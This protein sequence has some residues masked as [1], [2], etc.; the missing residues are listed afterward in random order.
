MFTWRGSNASSLVITSA[1]ANGTAQANANGT[2]TYAPQTGF[3]GS[4]TFTYTVKD[5]LGSTSNPATVTVHVPQARNDSYNVT[6]N[7]STSQTVNAATV[8]LNGVPNVAGR[9]FARQSNPVRTGGTGTGTLTITSFNTSTG[10]FSYRLSGAQAA[11]RGT[12][13]F[14][15]RMSLGGVST[16]PATVTIVV[17]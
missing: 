6:A 4:N 14:T 16:A 15:Y 2:V 9:S 17:R 11:K 3:A 12:F 7:T 10:A 8:A 5:S 1:P 13:Q